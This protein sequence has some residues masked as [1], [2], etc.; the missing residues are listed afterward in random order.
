MANYLLILRPFCPEGIEGLQWIKARRNIHTVRNMHFFLPNFEDLVDPDYDFLTDSYSPNRQKIGR[1]KHDWYAHQFFDEPIFDGMLISRAIV[2]NSVE[3]R[4]REVGGVH[5]YCRLDPAVPIMGDCGA[6]TYFKLN[7]PP[8]SSTE[9]LEYYQGLGFT[10]GVAIDHLI[11]PNMSQPERQRR[12]TITLQNAELFLKEHKANGY[13]FTPVGIAQ[14]WDPV[15]RR[16]AIEQLLK[17]GYDHLALGGM[18]R[19]QDEEIRQT[20][21]AIQPILP[22]EIKLHLFGVARLSLVPDLKQLGVTSTDSASPIRRAFLGTSEDNFWALDGQKYTAIRVPQTKKKAAKKRGIVSTQEIMQKNE[23]S[24]S[25]MRHLEQEALSFLRAYD[26]G[27]ADL[28]ETLEVLLKYD[29]LHGDKRDHRQAYRRTLKDH[30]WKQC[31]CAICRKYGVEVIIFR[32]NNRN[33]RRGFHNAWV[34]Y[35]QFNALIRDARYSASES[36]RRQTGYQMLLD[37]D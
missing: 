25:E 11:F 8:Y 16:Q 33:R 30:P 28:E 15:S 29:R 22:P 24:L 6:F 1:L 14:G 18:V 5:A 13:Q 23:I 4:I 17:F 37:L 10:H 35:H 26:A 3:K 12:F 9:I 19:S 36:P 2:T 31:P 20:L 27:E 32:G 34:F 7:E 21:A